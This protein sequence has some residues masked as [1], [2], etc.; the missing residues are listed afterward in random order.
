[1]RGGRLFRALVSSWG[2]S[3]KLGSKDVNDH[4]RELLHRLD[5]C[6]SRLDPSWGVPTFGVLYKATHL[7]GG[8]GPFFLADVVRGIAALGAEL[9]QDIYALDDDASDGDAAS[10]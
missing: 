4:C 8:N 1:M 3:S 9:W 7:S 5:G 2:I 10:S 6:A